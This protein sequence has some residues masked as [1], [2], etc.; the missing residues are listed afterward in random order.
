MNKYNCE[1]INFPS[2]KGDWE[3]FEKRESNKYS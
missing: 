1:G 2:E 3:K